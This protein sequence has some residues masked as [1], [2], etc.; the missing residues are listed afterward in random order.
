MSEG[1]AIVGVHEHPLR[2]APDYTPLRF[3]GECAAAALK[4][5]GL[6]P[7]DVDGLATTGEPM[8]LNYIA[9]YLNI[10]PRWL[11]MTGI[12]GS[13]FLAHILH[14]ADAIRQKR[15]NVVL[16]VY[17]SIARSSAVA[18]GSSPRPEVTDAT[19]TSDADAFD[20]PYGMILA[21][22][23]ALVANRHMH[24]YGTTHE[25]LAEIAVACRAHAALNPNA[26]YRDPITVAD[27]IASRPIAS[28]L[29]LLD[30]CVITDGG[31][32][33]IVA[34]GEVARN[35]RQKPVRILG[36]GE[37]LAHG[38]GGHRRLLDV[39]ARQ[40]GPAAFAAAGLKPADVDLAMIYDSFTITVLTTL[41]AMGFCKPGEGG[42]F[43]Q[44]GRLL[45]GGELPINLE[46]GALSNNHPGRRGIFLAI[47]AAHQLRGNA[48]ARQVRDAKIALCHGTGGYLGGRHSGVT[49]LLGS[50]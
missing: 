3:I 50:D 2:K 49:M 30:C 15:A 11:D 7:S 23:Y 38:Q 13:S 46:G 34:S 42:A 18:L 8:A 28:P 24:E 22:Y 27:V 37:G 36:G 21:S 26:R 17:G 29:H 16:V 33:V 31:G 20:I 19:S 14:A 40:T 32:A 4:D 5:A 12:G 44:N 9:E 41:E 6:K 47:E 1:P 43:V 25:Q 48:G 45:L 35:C 10:M 39:A